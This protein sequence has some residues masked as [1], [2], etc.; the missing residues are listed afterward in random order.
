MNTFSDAG[1]GEV[2]CRAAK[3]REK[4]KPERDSGDYQWHLPYLH[5]VYFKHLH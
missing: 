1:D 3:E 2:P 4:A 5:P